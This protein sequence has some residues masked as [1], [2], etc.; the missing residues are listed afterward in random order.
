M[1]WSISKPQIL[2]FCAS[3]ALL[4]SLVA[5]AAIVSGPYGGADFLPAVDGS[6]EPSSLGDGPIHPRKLLTSPTYQQQVEDAVLKTFNYLIGSNSGARQAA[7][8]SSTLLIS[9][10]QH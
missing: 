6:S 9:T 10:S 7:N 3:F 8:V 2:V 5:Q 4:T 1:A